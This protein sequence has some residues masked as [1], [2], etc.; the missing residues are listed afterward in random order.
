MLP[1]LISATLRLRLCCSRLVRSTATCLSRTSLQRSNLPD[2]RIP[3]TWPGV[4]ERPRAVTEA[5]LPGGLEYK[6]GGTP[7]SCPY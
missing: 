7:L 4:S 2:T 1:I 6:R 3:N 5:Q